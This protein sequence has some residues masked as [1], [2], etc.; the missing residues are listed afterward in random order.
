MDYERLCK[1]WGRLLKVEVG[2]GERDGLQAGLEFLSI[3]ATPEETQGFARAIGVLGAA[4]SALLVVALS[5]LIGFSFL[6]LLFAGFPVVLYFYLKKYPALKAESEKKKALSQMPETMSYLIMSLRINPNLERAIEF[7]ARHSH[8]LLMKKLEGIISNVRAGRSNTESDLLRLA[9][10][11]KK[12]DEFKRSIQLVISSTLERTEER[13][14]ATL[15][16]ANE[17]LLGGL[18]LRTEREARALNTPVMIVFTF[19][20]ILPLVFVAIIPFMSLMGIQIGAVSIAVMYTIGLPLLLFVL[21]KFISSNRPAT[22]APPNVPAESKTGFALV[23][24]AGASIALATLLFFGEGALG[25]MEYAPLLWAA[26]AGIGL[27]LL[28]TTRET[29]KLRKKTKELEKG[30]GEKLHEL[31]VVLSEGRPLEDS[32]SRI[33]SHFFRGA[34][35]NIRALNTDLQSAFFDGRFGSLR[36]VYSN[37]IKGVVEILVSISNKGPEAIA[38]VSFRMSEHISNLKKSEAEIE[39]ALGSVVSSMKIIAMVVA[40]LVGGMIS[41]MS[42]VLADTM[43][44][45]K[46]ANMGMGG[47]AVEPLDP[48]IIT[49]IIGIYAMESAAILVMFGNDLMNGDDKVMKKQAVGIALPVAV[50]VFTVCAWLAN[51][52]FG[53][54]S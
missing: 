13:R 20:V 49:L 27:F 9:D 30:F 35:G 24:A 18:S 6:W 4:G 7:A 47:K 17:V 10:D 41:S 21:I 45:T 53:G 8:G 43:E 48:S 5:L 19:G 40:P 23:A 34:A 14:H 16:K 37:T 46:G 52:L 50:F 15:D 51:G 44:K 11:F 3:G 33:D 36:E 29:K 22:M 12:W 54:I 32:M 2:G 1:S 39:R 42:I 26:G 31:G 28:M 38:A 25:A